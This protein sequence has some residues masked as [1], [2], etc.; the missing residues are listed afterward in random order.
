LTQQ[1]IEILIFAAVVLVVLAQLFVL[2][3]RASVRPT[4]ARF[5]MAAVGIAVAAGGVIAF[6]LFGPT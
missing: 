6:V 4:L 1:L 5:K 3:R 2:R